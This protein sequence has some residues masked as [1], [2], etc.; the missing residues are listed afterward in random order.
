MLIRKTKEED[1]S[2]MLEIYAHARQF[3]S[4]HG[5]PRQWAMRNW[6]PE[7]LLR[8]DIL[9]GDS[10]VCEHEGRVRGTF[11][12][13]QGKDVE[14][15][16]RIIRDGAWMDESPYGV[17]HRIATDGSV[18]G[19]GAFCINWAFEQCSHLRIDT[20]GDNKVMQNLLTKLGF[21]YC[22]II[23]VKE[24]S[25]PRLAYEKSRG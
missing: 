12:F 23:Y 14:P 18:K 17:I 5:N 11:F 20:H 13:I 2:R 7:E 15:N 1:L 19:T 22:G 10:Y 3:M 8:N 9:Q 21:T 24:D 6:P 16:Y 4:D 25:D